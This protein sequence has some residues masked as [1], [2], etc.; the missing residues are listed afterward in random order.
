MSCR[1]I[2]LALLLW[3]IIISVGLW[4]APAVRHWFNAQVEQVKR[5]Q[6]FRKRFVRDCHE[7]GGHV[8]SFGK[9]TISKA[10]IGPG[11]QWLASY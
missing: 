3:A 6:D 1:N 2:L 11:G 7:R 4:A 5:T 9:S 10:C 8:E